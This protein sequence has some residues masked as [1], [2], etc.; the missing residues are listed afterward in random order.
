MKKKLDENVK[1]FSDFSNKSWLVDNDGTIKIADTVQK[2]ING[3]SETLQVKDILHGNPYQTFQLVFTT[4]G[5]VYL[6]KTSREL[7]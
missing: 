6:L 5:G 2:I 3:G 4:E 7:K 1:T